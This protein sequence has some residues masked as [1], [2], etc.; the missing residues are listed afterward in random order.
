[1]TPKAYL[2]SAAYRTGEISLRICDIDGYQATLKSL[3]VP[4]AHELGPARFCVT[5]DVYQLVRESTAETVRACGLGAGAIDYVVFCSSHFAHAFNHRNRGLAAALLSNDIMP[6]AARGVC[7]LGCVDVLA[8]IEVALNALTLKA[9]THVL[10]IGLEAF[11]ESL[12]SRILDY[13]VISDAVVSFMVSGAPRPSATLEIVDLQSLTLL[14]RVGSGINLKDAK[15]Y[16]QTITAALES[17]KLQREGVVKVFGS[18]TF[19]L[20][21]KSREGSMGFAE[22]QMYLENIDRVGHCLACDPI[23][24]LIDYGVGR[25]SGHYLLFAEAEGHASAVL[26]AGVAASC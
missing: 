5:E 6:R 17:A 19:R 1:M 26:L 15:A 3:K 16:G 20:V 4:F 25:D 18:N 7:G 10:V 14:P 8:G 21:K 2:H 13:A 12:S 9:A 24:N 22:R 11:R 23:V